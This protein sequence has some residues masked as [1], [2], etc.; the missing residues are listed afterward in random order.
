MSNFSKFNSLRMRA[1]ELVGGERSALDPS[2]DHVNDLVH[3]LNVYRGELELQSSDLVDAQVALERSITT[4]KN[5]F[6]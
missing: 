4:W 5:F 1:E 2:L 3:E 6:D